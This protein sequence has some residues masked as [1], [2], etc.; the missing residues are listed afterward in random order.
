MHS[1]TITTLVL[2]Q[3]WSYGSGEGKGSH[4]T[5]NLWSMRGEFDDRLTWPASCTITLQL[6]NQAAN[7]DHVTVTK[8]FEWSKPTSQW[9]KLYVGEF[10]F[11][12]IGHKE[13]ETTAQ[14]RY[15]DDDRVLFRVTEVELK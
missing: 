8:A 14:V 6:L 5:V 9:E 4:V 15:I 3:V 13:L 7:Q 11:K 12:F 10:S 1:R 2:T